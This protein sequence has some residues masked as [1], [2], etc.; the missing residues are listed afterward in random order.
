MSVFKPV[1]QARISSEVGQQL[2]NAILTGQY[3]AGEKLPSERELIESFMVS[4]TVIR[5]AIKTLEAGGLVEIRQGAT[6]GAFVKH[7]TF[8][9]LS[10]ACHDLF[11][12]GKL[13]IP[14]VVQVRIL[15]E[16]QIAR[17]AARN[18]TPKQAIALVEANR[19]EGDTL[20]YREG[21]LLRSQVHY[22]L[23]EMSGNRFLEAITKS[24]L[25]LLHEELQKFEP[26]MEDMHPL[27]HHDALIEAVLDQDEDRAESEMRAHLQDFS[28]RLTNVTFNYLEK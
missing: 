22:L 4:R 5:E 6:G 10:G 24:L 7:L 25:I 26:P 21:V 20:D 18:C 15:L 3:K 1:K 14:E 11:M 23:A 16:P 27:G 12:M 13:S 9:H 2:K 19:R 17:L 8:E 28:Q